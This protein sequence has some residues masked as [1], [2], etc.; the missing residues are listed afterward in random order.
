MTLKDEQAIGG[1]LTHKNAFLTKCNGCPIASTH[2]R[3]RP[4]NQTLMATA[5][6]E[7]SSWSEYVRSVDHDRKNLPWDA[8]AVAPVE[9]NSM[10]HVSTA[11]N[12]C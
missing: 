2:R 1:K 11:F 3:E 7:A 12:A 9:R 10:Y 4:N 8:K 5:T 6:T